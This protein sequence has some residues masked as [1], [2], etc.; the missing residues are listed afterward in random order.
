MMWLWLLALGIG[1]FGVFVLLAEFSAFNNRELEKERLDGK[2]EW[3]GNRN[4]AKRTV[5]KEGVGR[6]KA[7]P[8]DRTGK[9]QY[10]SNL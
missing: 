9:T 10:N 3:K 6:S 4:T 8:T 1:Y 7:V 2:Q 5:T